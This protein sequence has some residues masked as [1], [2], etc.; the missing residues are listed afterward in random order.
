M[1]PAWHVITQRK[2][3]KYKKKK[4]TSPKGLS[5]YSFS[6]TLTTLKWGIPKSQSITYIDTRINKNLKMVSKEDLEAL[7]LLIWLSNGQD[8]ANKIH[9]N[10]STISRR[11]I[12]ACEKFKIKYKR[13]REKISI[14]SSPLDSLLK[15]ERQV[16][17]GIR[18][19]EGIKLRADLTELDDDTE[20]LNAKL[21]AKGW[22]TGKQKGTEIDNLAILLHERIIDAAI[23][24]TNNAK[25]LGVRPNG[26][27]LCLAETNNNNYMIVALENKFLELINRQTLFEISSV[28]TWQRLSCDQFSRE[29]GPRGFY[30]SEQK[31]SHSRTGTV[32]E[33]KF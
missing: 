17:Q 27:E 4:R 25:K 23:V 2:P 8:A 16:H 20:E 28:K 3:R 32:V 7:D 31:H 18:F 1:Q 22:V 11:Y 13:S 10:Q 26:K 9:C 29:Q 19:Y 30:K 12:Y 5:S 33:T 21:V 6:N 15:L 24:K 14:I